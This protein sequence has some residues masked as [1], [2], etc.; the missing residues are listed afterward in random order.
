M[1][2]VLHIPQ[3]DV[4][5]LVSINSHGTDR[6][7]ERV[8][9]FSVFHYLS[10]FEIRKNP[11]WT[12]DQRWLILRYWL[13][14]SLPASTMIPH[15]F[16]YLISFHAPPGDYHGSLQWLQAYP[17][18]TGVSELQRLPRQQL[19]TGTLSFWVRDNT[20]SLGALEYLDLVILD[21]DLSRFWLWWDAMRCG[22]ATRLHVIFGITIILCILVRYIICIKLYSQHPTKYCLNSNVP[23]YTKYSV[24]LDSIWCIHML[25]VKQCSILYFRLAG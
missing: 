24:P 9:K 20:V 8:E 21:S 1:A 14:L 15:H 17:C 7:K 12:F 22:V 23:F 6:K 19:T 11:Y 4:S 16:I 10:L 3:S 13:K 18:R 5:F 25:P 2:Y